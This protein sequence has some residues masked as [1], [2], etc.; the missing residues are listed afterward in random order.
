MIKSVEMTV[1]NSKV[2]GYTFKVEDQ[3]L[4]LNEY[5]RIIFTSRR[6][7]IT[8]I[9]PRTLRRSK[10]APSSRL[11]SIN[12]FEKAIANLLVRLLRAEMILNICIVSYMAGVLSKSHELSIYIA[13]HVVHFN[14]FYPLCRRPR[15]SLSTRYIIYAKI[16]QAHCRQ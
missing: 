1:S 6:K 14:P 9:Y 11:D 10:L 7:L 5:A 3:R 13:T 12:A 8:W 4:R 15:K 2:V 16:H